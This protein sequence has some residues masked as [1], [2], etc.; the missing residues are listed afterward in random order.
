M[1]KVKQMLYS[2][3]CYT[4]EDFKMYLN[5]YKDEDWCDWEDTDE[6]FYRWESLQLEQDLD[7][8]LCN[9]KY[10]KANEQECLIVGTLGLWDGRKEI[11]PTHCENLRDAILK[12][13]SG[14][15]IVKKIERVGNTIEVDI[16]HHDGCNCFS[17]VILSDKGRERYYRNDSVSL[18]NRENIYKIG[19]Y[20]F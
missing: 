8:L 18:N 11:I 1:K 2:D 15:C 17:I 6:D 7:D 3:N 16:A 20:L 5:E 14:D 4:Y 19:E 12:C 10:T 9:L 13:I